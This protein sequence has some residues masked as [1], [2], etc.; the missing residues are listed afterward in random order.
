MEKNTIIPRITR[1]WS[2]HCPEKTIFRNFSTESENKFLSYRKK[3]V[4]IFK[5]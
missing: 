4:V 2:M 3:T 5:M 1:Y